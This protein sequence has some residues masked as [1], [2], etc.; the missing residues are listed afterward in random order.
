MPLPLFA[1][2]KDRKL[3]EQVNKEMYQLYM[4]QM[5][6][7]KL[8]FRTGTEVYLY[9]ED[10]HRDIPN[11][12]TYSI[13]AYVD[14]TDNGIAALYKQGQ[15]LD[16]QLYVYTSRKGLEDLLKGLSLDPYRDV[17]TDGDVVRIQDGLWEV[18]T[19]DPEGYHM[20]DRRYPFDFQFFIAPL[21]R[22]SVPQDDT[23]EQFPRY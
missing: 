1:S 10:V 14:V 15:Q 17:P 20:N 2:T 16:R 8:S 9:H 12:V 21:Q 19:V 23:R 11:A 7:Y 3:L 5:D 22:S 6:V 18:M 4:H 13:E